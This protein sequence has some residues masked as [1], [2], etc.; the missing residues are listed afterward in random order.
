MFQRRVTP[1]WISQESLGISLKWGWTAQVWPEASGRWGCLNT[2]LLFLTSRW[3]AK[4]HECSGL[5]LD[6]H[7]RNDFMKTIILTLSLLVAVITASAQPAWPTNVIVKLNHLGEVTVA[8]DK[9]PTH[10]AT[11]TFSVLIGVRPGVY[12]VRQDV[13]TNTTAVV[14]NLPAGATYYFSVV[15]RNA[16]GIDSDPSNEVSYPL[17]KPATTPGVRTVSVKAVLKS[18]PYPDGPWSEVVKFPAHNFLARA[19]ARF[20]RIEGELSAGAFITN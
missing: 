8:W 11:T 10:V 1:G 9:A 13:G 3:A 20:Y 14:T 7:P 2:I 12:N 16:Q 18:A 15:A 6:L 17:A 5:D 19:N 4:E